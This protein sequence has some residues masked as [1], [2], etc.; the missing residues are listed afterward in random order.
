MHIILV[1]SKMA[2]TKTFS[3]TSRTLWLAAFLFVGISLFLSVI[4][5]WASIQYQLPFATEFVNS[6]HQEGKRKTDEY[7]RENVS[8]MASR[9]GEMQAKLLRLDSLGERIAKL[10]GISTQNSQDSSTTRNPP[11][12]PS[13]K[14]AA[15][16]DG[17]GGPLIRRFAP[18]SSVELNDEIERLS[19]LLD[20]RGEKLIELESQLME[21]R[22][23]SSLLPTL[24]PIKS[25]RVGSAYGRRQDPIVG[26]GA[27]HEGIDFS[28]VT[29]TPVVASAGGVVVTAEYHPQYGYMVDVD[30]G[31]DFLSRYAHLSVLDVKPG[32]I[33]K[34]GQKIAASGNTGRS[35]GPHLHFEIRFKGAVQNPSRFLK[36][37]ALTLLSEEEIQPETTAVTSPETQ[38]LGT[39]LVSRLKK[40][41]S[42][43]SN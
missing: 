40:T 42:K 35:T 43:K 19:E 23:K 33:V 28:A 12:T 9:L 7:L 18:L 11:N 22:I 25:H 24:L 4:F 37:T 32:Q 16:K 3:I 31:N 15:S 29:G 17:Q 41:F 10:S 39:S 2:S 13:K 26:G 30:H 21:R 14:G 5:S 38:N 20:E 1:S 6:V 8:L 36:N 27:M 34:R